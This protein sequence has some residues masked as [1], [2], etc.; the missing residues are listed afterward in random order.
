MNSGDAFSNYV[1]EELK[2]DEVRCDNTLTCA[3]TTDM[4][5]ISCELLASEKT[6]FS[7]S[8][9][10]PPDLCTNSAEI[11]NSSNSQIS[12]NDCQ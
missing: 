12:Q 9:T 8:G 11:S 4:S 2:V 6:N 7:N 5:Q 1:N 10:C 3:N